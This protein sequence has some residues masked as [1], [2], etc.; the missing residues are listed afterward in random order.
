MTLALIAGRGQLPA[1]IAAAQEQP[2]LV[3]AYDGAAPDDLAADVTF[4]LETLGTLLVTLGER[5][6]TDVCFAGGLDRPAIDPALI[7]AETAP[8]MPL[9]Q[10]ALKLGDD[11]ALKVVVDLFQKTGFAVRGAHELVPELLAEGGVYGDAWPDAEMRADAKAGAAHLAAIGAQDIGQA[12]IVING[13]IIA[14]EDAE[15]TD[16]LIRRIVRLPREKRPILFKAPKPQQTR[17]VDLPTIGPDTIDAAGKAGFAGVVIDAGDV[18]VIN[19]ER[20]AALANL[21]GLVLWA[22]TGE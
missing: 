19:K 18:L 2:P 16:S 5:G 1:I 21:H 14:T 12:C 10:E 20:C 3:C 17:L 22:R 11:G 4:R 7:D 9:F 8:L 6:V 13:K 15:G